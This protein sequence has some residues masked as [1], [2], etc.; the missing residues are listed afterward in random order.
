MAITTRTGRPI[1]LPPM[2]LR[3]MKDSDEQF[4]K[5]G[6]SLAQLLYRY[7]LESDHALIDVGCNVGRVP[8]GLLAG[9]DFAGRYLGFDVIKPA[10]TW[11]AHNLARVAPG[12][13]F[14]HLDVT[15]DRYNPKGRVAPGDVRFPAR[16]AQFDVCCL[17][18]IFTH[19]Y[20]EDIQHYLREIRRVLKPGGLVVATW[21]LYD[22]ERLPR[23]IA[24]TAYPMAHRLD[25]VTIYTELSDPLRA[26]AFDQDY[27]RRIVEDAGLEVVR[28]DRGTWAGEEGDEFQDFV[29]LRRPVA[30]V[31]PDP[32]VSKSSSGLRRVYEAIDR[33]VG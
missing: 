6:I 32:E 18:S 20:K 28:I 13:T 5:S 23:A 1:P 29:V 24:S 30:D 25:E 3:L 17:F 2:K 19:F 15:N 14:V 11:A 9:T 26:I 7:G 8:V 27:V 21:F 12:F 31:A 33:R 22:E 16:T 4:V 10:V